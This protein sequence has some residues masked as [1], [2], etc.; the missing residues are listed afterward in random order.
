MAI[1]YCSR[2][3]GVPG[4]HFIILSSPLCPPP[5]STLNICVYLFPSFFLDP[6]VLFGCSDVRKHS[7]YSGNH[8][9][10]LLFHGIKRWQTLRKGE[11][12]VEKKE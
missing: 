10:E 9:Q 2:I 4:C 7:I 5:R 11:A 3:V 12:R 8:Y 6:R 1:K